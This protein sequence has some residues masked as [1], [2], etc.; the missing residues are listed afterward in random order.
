MNYSQAIKEIYEGKT[1]SRE[2]WNGKWYI[3]YMDNHIWKASGKTART[4]LT[5][6]P[7]DDDVEATDWIEYD[8]PI[9]KTEMGMQE[10][11]RTAN[12]IERQKRGREFAD[13]NGHWPTDEEFAEIDK[14]MGFKPRNSSTAESAYNFQ[15]EL[16]VQEY[17]DLTQ[18]TSIKNP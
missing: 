7:E 13:K 11:Q 9:L 5:Y 2:I 15:E 10:K 14:S 6:M 3:K 17:E 16:K 1:F 12:Y 18:I 4:L 8:P